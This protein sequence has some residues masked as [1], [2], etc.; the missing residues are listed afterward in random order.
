[1]ESNELEIK[2]SVLKSG[3]ILYHMGEDNLLIQECRIMRST[4]QCYTSGCNETEIT[5][6]YTAHD[7]YNN[8]VSIKGSEIGK[9]YFL[10]KAE[11]LKAIAE[12]L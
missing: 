10:S 1:M 3:T 8:V 9:K 5:E 6:T 12:Q 7:C 2:G 11:I 4:M